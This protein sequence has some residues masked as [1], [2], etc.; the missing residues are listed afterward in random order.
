M[1]LN[2]ETGTNKPWKKPAPK[3]SLGKLLNREPV[4]IKPPKKKVSKPSVVR[5][6]VV[7]PKNTKPKATTAWEQKKKIETAAKKVSQST[8]PGPTKTKPKPKSNALGAADL[9]IK[10]DK[11]YTAAKKPTASKST[12]SSTKSGGTSSNGTSSNSTSSNSNS[13]TTKST[14]TS[15]AT[16]R[17][18]QT[19]DPAYLSSIAKL[20]D[21]WKQANGYKGQIDTMMTGGFTYDPEK[22]A[23]Y[24]S[25]QTLAT[26]NAKIASGEALETMNDRGILNSTVTS[27]RLGQIE[28]TAQDA[29]TAQVPNLKNAAYGQYMDKLGTLNNLWNSTVAM[30]QQ[31]RSF[32]EDKRRWELGYQMD[33]DQFNTAKDQWNQTFDYNAAQDSINNS[34][35]DSQLEIDR[36]NYDL[37]AVKQSQ[38]AIGVNNKTE[39]QS[40]ITELLLY[41]TKA[42]IIKHLQDNVVKYNRSGANISEILSALN[43]YYPGIEDEAQ[44]KK[45]IKLPKK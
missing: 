9:R 27:D 10:D 20:N 26:K 37:N 2:Q 13:S 30:A 7:L 18:D 22:D 45:T 41:K 42:D 1:I 36:L 31:E 19:K 43:K 12:S 14:T 21:L 17:Y 5:K 4:K 40:A 29:V 33:Q 38:D 3:P 44:G 35:K 11:G 25:L 6:S 23:S 15:S 28:Q 8:K 24:K 34:F 32:S 39:T 16:Y